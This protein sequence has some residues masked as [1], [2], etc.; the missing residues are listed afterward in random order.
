MRAKG[1]RKPGGLSLEQD[2]TVWYTLSGVDVILS[3]LG[4]IVQSCPN[5]LINLLHRTGLLK[6][7]VIFNFVLQYF[8]KQNIKKGDHRVHSTPVERMT[9]RDV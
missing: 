8:F 9:S 4:L 3:I 7:E 2:N 6:M 5:G 1:S